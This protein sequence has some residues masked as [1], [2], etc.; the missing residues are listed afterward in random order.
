VDPILR[1]SIGIQ[2]RLPDFILQPTGLLPNLFKP[3]TGGT[4][5]ASS[6]HT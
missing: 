1:L 6:V 5:V 4:V 3:M 2:N